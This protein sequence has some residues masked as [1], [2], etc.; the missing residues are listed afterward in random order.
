MKVN[1]IRIL[2]G[3]LII[4]ALALFAYLAKKR[5]AN[6]DDAQLY[7]LQQL[8]STLPVAPGLTQRGSS[9]QSKAESALVEN[10]FDSSVPFDEVKS[11]YYRELGK[12][13]WL[14]NE[15]EKVTDWGRDFGGRTV[16]F[17]KEQYSLT[18][19]YA[20]NRDDQWDYAISLTW[21]NST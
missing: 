14:L 12:R 5:S 9:F 20:G 11:F 16:K 18:I 15:E 6:R 2:I 17:R 21:K 1:P 3:I 10:Y 13:G 19:E 4:A 8:Y 7:K